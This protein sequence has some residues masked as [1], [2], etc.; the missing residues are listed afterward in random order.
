[1]KIKSQRN[2]KTIPKIFHILQANLLLK[3]SI[4]GPAFIWVKWFLE[5]NKYNDIKSVHVCVCEGRKCS[6]I[7]IRLF[8][9]HKRRPTTRISF[10]RSLISGHDTSGVA[11]VFCWYRQMR[12]LR[13][14][15][16]LWVAS[17]LASWGL[18]FWSLS[19]SLWPS[20]HQSNPAEIKKK[21]H[22]KLKLVKNSNKTWLIYTNISARGGRRLGLIDF[23]IN[24]HS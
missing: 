19:W 2:N 16:F 18:W 1:M 14:S 6:Q 12:T 20:T 22:K 24:R 9:W 5:K 13:P 23:K 7:H 8:Y 21:I 10:C 3:Q 4:H 17:I 15:M 11:V